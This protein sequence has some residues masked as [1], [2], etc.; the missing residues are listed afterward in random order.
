MALSQVQIQPLQQ[1]TCS[2]QIVQTGRGKGGKNKEE[3][4][5]ATTRTQL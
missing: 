5:P 3:P 4:D 2:K 1:T